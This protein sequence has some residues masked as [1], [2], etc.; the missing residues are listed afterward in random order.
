MEWAGGKPLR[1][2]PVGLVTGAPVGPGSLRLDATIAYVTMLLARLRA[3]GTS[4]GPR[5][6]APRAPTEPAPSA[7]KH[8]PGAT[9]KAD[10]REAPADAGDDLPEHVRTFLDF[11]VERAVP[12]WRD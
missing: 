9:S 2:A 7:V 1:H 4:A 10:H 8:P 6:P 3:A 5:I 12:R 11:L